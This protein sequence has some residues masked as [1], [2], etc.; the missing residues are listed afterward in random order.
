MRRVAVIGAG[1]AGSAAAM[2]LAGFAGIETLLVERATFP[3]QKACGSGLSP[4]VRGY[5]TRKLSE[6]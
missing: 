2:S 5:L 6:A 4:P 3:R 1:P